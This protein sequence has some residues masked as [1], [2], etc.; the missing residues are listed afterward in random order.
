MKRLCVIL[1]LFFLLSMTKLASGETIPNQAVPQGAL[2]VASKWALDGDTP[3][4]FAKEIKVGQPQVELQNSFL[5]LSSKK[6]SFGLKK[7]LKASIKDYPYIHWSWQARNLPKGGDF[8]KKETDDQA[9]QLYVL[10]P[11]APAKVNTRILG[12]LWENETPKGTS[13]TSTAWPKLKCI[14][15]RDKTDPLGVWYN[16]SRNIYEDYKNLFN[17]EPPELG[18]V[19]IYINSQHTGS[20]AEILYG[21]IFF[22]REPL[23]P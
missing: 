14:V 9:G 21:P 23:S 4:G 6:T 18:G 15:L 12:Y 3:R 1:L 16:E 17:E 8:R 10:F 7:D 22:T 5:K 11:R 13:G 19:A 2:V 20:E